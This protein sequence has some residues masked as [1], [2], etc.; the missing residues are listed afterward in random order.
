MPLSTISRTGWALFKAL[1]CPSVVICTQ[2]GPPRT[3]HYS[4]VGAGN[5]EPNLFANPGPFPC[6]HGAIRF[7]FELCKKDSVSHFSALILWKDSSVIYVFNIQG[8]HLQNLLLLP[9]RIRSSLPRETGRLQWAPKKYRE[10][11]NRCLL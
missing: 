8:Q 9:P 4:L 11:T 2:R 1:R 6:S 5:S 7:S 10:H 3:S